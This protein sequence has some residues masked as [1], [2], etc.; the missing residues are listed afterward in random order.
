MQVRF[1]RYRSPDHLLQNLRAD[2]A[3]LLLQAV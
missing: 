3:M 2:F 1:H